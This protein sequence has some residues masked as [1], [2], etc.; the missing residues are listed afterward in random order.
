[1]AFFGKSFGKVKYA[2]ALLGFVLAAASQAHSASFSA[3]TASRSVATADYDAASGNTI[4]SVNPASP[5]LLGKRKTISSNQNS[6][7]N[8]LSIP[9][10]AAGVLFAS[11]AL[12]GSGIARRR[13]ARRELG[14]P[15]SS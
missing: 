12:L 15:P 14:M 13:R 5:D 4:A 1:M 6:D 9:V 8:T 2:L 7:D 10:P 11:A 3:E